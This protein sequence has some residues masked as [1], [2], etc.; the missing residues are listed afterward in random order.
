MNATAKA[1]MAPPDAGRAN[2]GFSAVQ[3]ETSRTGRDSLGN[4]VR[5]TNSYP[6]APTERGAKGPLERPKESGHAGGE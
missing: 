1:R 6:Y 3:P 5:T 2:K 4:P